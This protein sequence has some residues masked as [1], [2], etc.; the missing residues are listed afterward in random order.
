MT[1]LI[2]R[3]THHIGGVEFRN[4][5]KFQLLAVTVAN[6]AV[7]G[8]EPTDE[9]IRALADA[10]DH[11]QPELDAQLDRL[12]HWRVP[13]AKPAIT[14][15]QALAQTFL[16]PNGTLKNKLG[17]HDKADLDEH[18]FVQGS[19]VG[20]RMLQRGF[21]VSSVDNLCRI[22]WALFGDLYDWA[23]ELRNYNL[24]KQQ[25]LFLPPNVFDNGIRSVNAEITALKQQSRPQIA[26]YA[27]LLDE[28]NYL[29]PFR[30]GNG[31][32]IRILIELLANEKG[33][34]LYYDAE[35]DEFIQALYDS[36]V[37]VLTRKLH[38]TALA[39]E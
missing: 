25:T 28:L 32:A 29:H 2:N 14:D 6:S 17:I 18:E 1:A 23:G 13:V 24:T 20:L 21:R 9:Q 11:P 8:W 10:Y 38:L 31:R 15:E 36:K 22:N 34:Y 26:A 19:L 16:Y 12:R 39:A 37:D 33:Q 30:E 7:E 3:K 4:P 5:R 27:K 35:D